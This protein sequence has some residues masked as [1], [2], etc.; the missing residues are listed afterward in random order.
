ML[1]CYRTQ[2][3]AVLCWALTS[4]ATEQD[5]AVAY[6]HCLSKPPYSYIHCDEEARRG[7]P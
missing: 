6:W 5:P 3:A 4:C 7:R 1:R 2:L